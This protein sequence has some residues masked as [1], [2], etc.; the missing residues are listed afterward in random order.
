MFIISRGVTGC[1]SRPDYETRDSRLSNRK[2]TEDEYER[3]E[4][5]NKGEEEVRKLL[6]RLEYKGYLV[7]NGP[8]LEFNGRRVEFDHI[9][10]GNN[11]V[12]SLET[13]AFGS[14][15]NG[16]GRASLFIDKG[17][18]WILRKNGNNRELKSPTEQILS[19]RDHLKEILHSA[20]ERIDVKPIL[21]LSNKELFLKNNIRLE[22]EVVLLNNLEELIETSMVNRIFEEEKHL[23]AQIIDEHRINA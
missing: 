1:N 22:Y 23:I 11:G 13:K 20:K 17:D 14:S 9:V 6:N 15:V 8:V 10:I 2:E 21:V 5:G 12:F 7:I 3:K 16:K 18:K 19:E 4:V